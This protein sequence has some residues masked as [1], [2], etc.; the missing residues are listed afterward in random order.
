MLL[1]KQ[2]VKYM[3]T[4]ISKDAV[5]LGK[6]S[7]CEGAAFTIQKIWVQFYRKMPY[8]QISLKMLVIYRDVFLA[9]FLVRLDSS[10]LFL[11]N[12]SVSV[13]WFFKGKKEYQSINT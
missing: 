5:C 1:L 7:C 2:H 3:M 6:G 13:L 11:V 12:S 10:V 9:Y 8:K 4:K